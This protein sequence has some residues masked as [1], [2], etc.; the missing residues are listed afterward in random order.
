[1]LRLD[2]PLG[3]PE[4]DHQFVAVK[5]RFPEARERIPLSPALLA[6][7]RQRLDSD[8]VDWREA[9]AQAHPWPKS[10]A[11]IRI[12]PRSRYTVQIHS[13]TQAAGSAADD[14]ST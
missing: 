11:E 10:A 4:L 14:E 13:K 5:Q 7:A 12:T 6:Y 1:M 8:R 2:R 3:L 9:D